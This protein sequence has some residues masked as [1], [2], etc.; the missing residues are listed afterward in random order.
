MNTNHADRAN[1]ASRDD[2]RANPAGNRPKTTGD[3]SRLHTDPAVAD[4]WLELIARR[5][6]KWRSVPEDVLRREVTGR[7][8]CMA[9]HPD[10][11]PPRELFD[12]ATDRETAAR[13]CAG[14]PVIDT[15]LEWELRLAGPYTVGV[16][17]ALNEDDRCELYPLWLRHRQDAASTQ[18][19]EDGPAAEGGERR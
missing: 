10:G 11:D 19:T 17:G 6:R 2:N 12:D 15:C 3:R 13:L 8:A 16:W 4:G 1:H 18:D 7:G 5:L 14:C 9:V